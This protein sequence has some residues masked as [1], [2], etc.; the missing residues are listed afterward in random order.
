[1]AQNNLGASY[2]EGRGVAQDYVEAVRW[3]RRAAEQALGRAQ[4]NLGLRYANGEGVPQ[5]RVEALM[6]FTLAANDPEQRARA[7]RQANR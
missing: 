2:A 1:M 5:D 3:F 6:W 4:N 7:I